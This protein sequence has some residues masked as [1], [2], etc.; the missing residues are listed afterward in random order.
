M[1]KIT[2]KP[3]TEKENWTTEDGEEL[4][5]DVTR[6]WY[7][8]SVK[9]HRSPERCRDAIR[10]VYKGEELLRGEGY[11]Q[12]THADIGTLTEPPRIQ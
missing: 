9:N 12:W 1:N 8:V 7:R 4:Q 11:R 10:V 6:E 5:V 2:L 3:R